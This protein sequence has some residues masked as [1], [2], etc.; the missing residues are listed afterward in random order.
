M[1]RKTFL[2]WESSV[3]GQENSSSPRENNFQDCRE[4]NG[5]KYVCLLPTLPIATYIRARAETGCP[6]QTQDQELCSLGWWQKQC[7]NHRAKAS[8][9]VQEGKLSGMW[10]LVCSQCRDGFLGCFQACGWWHSLQ[11]GKGSVSKI[12]PKNSFSFSRFEDK[13]MDRTVCELKGRVKSSG[14]FWPFRSIR[15]FWKLHK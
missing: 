2:S 12:W 6:A 5:W 14:I 4:N 1:Q 11:E 13:T 15:T 7:G 8:D 3:L 10:R 9:A